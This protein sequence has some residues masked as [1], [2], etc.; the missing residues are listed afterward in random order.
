MRHRKDDL[1]LR[2]AIEY[3][4]SVRMEIRVVLLDLIADLFHPKDRKWL[5]PVKT[6][7]NS[8]TAEL[9]MQ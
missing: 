1:A 6:D 7:G 5:L 8:S 9:E 3:C 2:A 4:Y